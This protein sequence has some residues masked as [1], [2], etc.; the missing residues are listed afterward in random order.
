MDRQYLLQLLT[1]WGVLR[2]EAMKTVSD[3]VSPDGVFLFLE[4]GM[5][6][7]P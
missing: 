7:V 5:K 1:Q 6:I 2:M 4:K 3:K